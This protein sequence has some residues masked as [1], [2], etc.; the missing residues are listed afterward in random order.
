MQTSRAVALEPIV[1]GLVGIA[2]LVLMRRR[3]FWIMLFFFGALASFFA[4]VA[5]AIHFQ[6]L[7]AVGFLV[8]ICVNGAIGSLIAEG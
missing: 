2:A 8:L 3:W 1:I 5:A 4:M 6:I 7:G